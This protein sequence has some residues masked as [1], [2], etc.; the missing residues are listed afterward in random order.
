MVTSNQLHSPSLAPPYDPDSPFSLSA[1]SKLQATGIK[2]ETGLA[3]LGQ[4]FSDK[5][6]VLLG[7]NY[8]LDVDITFD[9]D[10]MLCWVAGQQ[11]GEYPP[12]WRSLCTVVRELGL[13]ELSQQ[14]EECLN[15]EW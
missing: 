12:T 8:F 7:D 9:E 3:N 15:G 13:Q 2:I 14:M 5:V 4:R 11:A 6:A 10:E 1:L